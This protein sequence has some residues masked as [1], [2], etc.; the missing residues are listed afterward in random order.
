MQ[1]NPTIVVSPARTAREHGQGLGHVCEHSNHPAAWRGLAQHFMYFA[2]KPS[3]RCEQTCNAP[4]ALLC[5]SRPRADCLGDSDLSDRYFFRPTHS[6][7]NL[8]CRYTD[9]IKFIRGITAACTTRGHSLRHSNE[10]WYSTANQCQG[11]FRPRDICHTHK[12]H[13]PCHNPVTH[14]FT[15]H[16][17]RGG[18][19]H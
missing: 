6:N 18:C 5:R 2:S 15:R 11:Y 17:A 4:Q 19:V 13:E 7:W 10:P 14:Q 8:C 16:A 1:A 12:S 3:S 9:T